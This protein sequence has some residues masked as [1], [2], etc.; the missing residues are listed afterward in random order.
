MLS[1]TQKQTAYSS[2]STL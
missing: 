1:K 2:R